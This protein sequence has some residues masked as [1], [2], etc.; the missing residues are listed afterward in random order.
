MA[1]AQSKKVFVMAAVQDIPNF[2]PHVIT[3]YSA[4]WLLRN[5]YD[6]LIRVDA[7][8]KGVAPNLAESWEVSKDGLEYTFKLS[9]EAKFHNGRA[10]TAEDV[11]YSFDRLLRINKGVS[12]MIKGIVDADNI[13]VI[14]EQTIKIKLNKP[15]AAFLQVLP[16]VFIVDAKTLQENTGADD[17]QTYLKDKVIGSGPFSLKRFEPGNL[18]EVERV[19]KDWHKG[20]G[21]LTNAIWKITRE[22]NTQRLMVQKG[23]AHVALDLGAEDLSA[24]KN[25]K[26]L[27]VI[28]KPEYAP[29]T[30][31]MNTKYGPLADV[32]LRKAVAYA[33][34]YDALM[35]AAVD[36]ELMNGPLPQ[37][38]FG[39]DGS[40]K[41]P[42]Y[43][44]EKAKSFLAKTK[45]ANGGLKL[46][47]LYVNGLEKERKYAL[48]MLDALKKLN[49]ELDIVPKVWPDMVATTKSPETFPDFFMVYQTSNY[50]DPD[51]IVFASYHSSRN[52]GWQNPVYANPEV[53]SLIEKARGELDSKARAKLYSDFQKKI[54]EDQ[55]EI[56]GVNEKRILPF[57]K[58]V[59]GYKFVPIGSRSIDL[60]PLSLN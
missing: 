35:T 37:A 18:Y 13:K 24:I 60:L 57:R 41:S 28:V 53:D 43:D 30:V 7:S 44:L 15:F 12:W 59:K 19:A 39:Y 36:A 6:P 22:S 25:D 34:D 50:N 32:N 26:N 9:P 23:E 11:R 33:M 17:G 20:G 27:N 16:W 46:K 42:R 4:M 5:V 56:F 31:K 14:D 2:D 45:Y 8:D 47:V 54:I 21:N 48:V 3:G 51:N 40:I 10:V 55:P 52:G 49:I 58:E 1:S 29:F 38:M